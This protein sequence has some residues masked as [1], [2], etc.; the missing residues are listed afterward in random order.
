MTNS[1]RPCQGRI[2]ALCPHH[3]VAQ[4]AVTVAD[5]EKQLKSASGALQSAYNGQD[6]DFVDE[7]T[8]Q[9]KRLEARMFIAS[10]KRNYDYDS[11]LV[12]KERARM[13][14]E[15]EEYRETALK[16]ILGSD[17]PEYKAHQTDLRKEIGSNPN[18]YKTFPFR[19]GED[20]RDEKQEIA[21]LKSNPNG[22]YA[23]VER[24]VKEV[25]A[26]GYMRV[27][28]GVFTEELVPYKLKPGQMSPSERAETLKS[29]KY[30]E[31]V[32]AVD[33]TVSELRRG[34]KQKV[35]IRERIFG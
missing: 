33:K 10:G 16:T 27:D 25:G 35:D 2:P 24:Y 31:A 19:L 3:G 9:K 4:P 21:A 28:T 6:F 20:L 34:I 17:S 5:I 22:P 13:D 8:T 29:P 1:S 18:N 12:N 26:D 32:T 30:V 7:L 23:S 14:S 11:P 15:I